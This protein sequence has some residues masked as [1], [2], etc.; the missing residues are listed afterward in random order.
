MYYRVYRVNI[1]DNFFGEIAEELLTGLL[2][3]TA[4]LFTTGQWANNFSNSN[5][6]EFDSQN[7]RLGVLLF[8]GVAHIFNFIIWT[9]VF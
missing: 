5:N 9:T 2:A 3:K 1:F 6:L 8:F 4:V 7:W